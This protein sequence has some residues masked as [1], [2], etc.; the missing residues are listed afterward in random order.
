MR[1]ATFLFDILKKARD[2]SAT[3]R[4]NRER[5]PYSASDNH[6]TRL[7]SDGSYWISLE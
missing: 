4:I 7:F 3:D 6:V 2:V 1:D 5:S